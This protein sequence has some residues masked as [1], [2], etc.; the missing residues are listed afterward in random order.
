MAPSFSIVV[1]HLVLFVA[2]ILLLLGGTVS[3]NKRLWAILC[4]AT[5]A[6]VALCLSLPADPPAPDAAHAPV[7]RDAL[8]IG[9]EW[10][11]LGLGFLLTLMVSTAEDPSTTSSTF[12]GWLLLILSG[13]MLVSVANDLVVLFLGLEILAMSTVLMLALAAGGRWHDLPLLIKTWDTGTAEKYFLLSIFASAVLLYGF[14]FLYGLSGTTNLAAMHDAFASASTA[15]AATAESELASSPVSPLG[16]VALVLVFASLGFRAGLVPFDLLTPDVVED[17]QPAH[18]AVLTT[19]H[20]TAALAALIRVLANGMVG[21]EANMLLVAFVVSLA[22]MIPSS[23]LALAESKLPRLLAYFTMAHC[24][25]LL[26]G[27]TAAF[28]DGTARQFGFSTASD[29]GWPQAIP[30]TLLY[31]CSYCLAVA[32]LFSVLVYAARPGQRIQHVEE[33]SGLVRTEPLA[34]G[35]A[36]VCLLSLAGLP[37]LSGFWSKLFVLASSLS[38]QADTPQTLLSW[39]HPICVLLAIAAVVTMVLMVAVS[40]RLLRVIVLDNPIAR[41]QPAGGQGALAAGLLVAVLAVGIGLLP[42]PLLGFL[43]QIDLAGGMP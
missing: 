15:S 1:P 34:A 22:T 28:A 32:G 41:P 9:L 10:L 19:I 38:V 29:V 26:I 7:I 12:F 20:R 4:L 36:V 25:F 35:T 33:L 16:T 40:F 18:A 17:V 24:G 37:P 39:P 5:L 31:L 23:V 27:L 43:G 6:I 21:Y 13:A 42:G 30:S 11:L 14:S 3:N 8:A 2:G